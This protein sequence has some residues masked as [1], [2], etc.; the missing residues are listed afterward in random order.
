MY[1][2][3]IFTYPFIISTGFTKDADA[4][5]QIFRL[6]VITG[7]IMFNLKVIG[8]LGF[9]VCEFNFLNNM[10]FIHSIFL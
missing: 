7:N 4:F 5:H 2:D 9:I 10:L 6:P 8:V 3:N 1:G